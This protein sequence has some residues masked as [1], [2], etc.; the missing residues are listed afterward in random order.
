MLQR[1]KVGSMTTKAFVLMEND[2]RMLYIDVKA[3]HRVD[4][5]RL[6]KIAA[7]YPNNMLEGMRKEKVDN[8]RM[9]IVVYDNLIQV[10]SK[11]AGEAISKIHD[12]D[13]VARIEE[14]EKGTTEESSGDSSEENAE[15][16]APTPKK[17]GRPK[18]NPEE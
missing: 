14:A 8:G 11:P 3:L 15:E 2:S 4:Y 10:L 5:E 7:K 9:A 1:I 13:N 17:R 12:S 18:K 16:E 6:K